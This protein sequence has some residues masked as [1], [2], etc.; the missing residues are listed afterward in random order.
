MTR[1]NSLSLTRAMA[2]KFGLCAAALLGAAAVHAAEPYVNATIGGEVAPGVY[3]RIEIGNRPPPP[4]LYPQPV[5]I[6]QVPVAVRPA[7]VYLY[8]PPGHA[9]NWRKHCHR[10][11]A[12]DRPVYFLDETRYMKEHGKGKGKGK[13]GPPG[14]AHGHGKKD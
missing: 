10:Y 4:V 5:I 8:V 11:D 13:G 7:P 2:V 14:H 6:K 3:G 1:R 9:K 12:C